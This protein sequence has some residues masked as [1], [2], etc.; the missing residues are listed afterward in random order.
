MKSIKNK[1]NFINIIQVILQLMQLCHTS[2]KHDIEIIEL[3]FPSLFPLNRDVIFLLYFSLYPNRI[4]FIIF[5]NLSS[6]KDTFILNHFGTF[7]KL[8]C[9]L[10]MT[11]NTSASS[12]SRSFLFSIFWNNIF[13]HTWRSNHD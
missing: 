7:F 11:T 6:S 8:K 10:V 9:D 3:I 2:F 12:L 4:F 1:E 13:W 5:F